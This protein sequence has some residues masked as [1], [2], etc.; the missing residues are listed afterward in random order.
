M[1]GTAASGRALAIALTFRRDGREETLRVLERIHR[2]GK[3]GF[4][5]PRRDQPRIGG[6]PGVERLGHRAEIGH[7]PARLRGGKRQRRRGFFRGEPAQPG[8]GRRRGDRAEN[9]GWVPALAVVV[10]GV[11]A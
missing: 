4:G 5:H 6:A 7:Q 3:A 11:A 1:P 10:A 8:A 9:P 2:G